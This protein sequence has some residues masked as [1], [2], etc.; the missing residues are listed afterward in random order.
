[1]LHEKEYVFLNETTKKLFLLM[2]GITNHYAT[3]QLYFLL[4]FWSIIKKMKK[5]IWPNNCVTKKWDD[6]KLLFPLTFKKSSLC[7]NIFTNRDII[8]EE[9]SR[10]KWCKN[11][12]SNALPP[13]LRTS[14]FI[15][16]AQKHN[17]EDSV[18][19]PSWAQLQLVSM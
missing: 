9:C 5:K 11:V 10:W 15:R 7:A 18:S 12:S 16:N 3:I 4:Y 6:R 1:M 8:Q 14:F 13:N 19:I 2:P 17:D